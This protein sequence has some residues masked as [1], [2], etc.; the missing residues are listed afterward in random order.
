[1]K[2][3]KKRDNPP[4]QR[5]TVEMRAKP[6]G[7]VDRIMFQGQGAWGSQVQ[8]GSWKVGTPTQTSCLPLSPA[9]WDNNGDLTVAIPARCP[10][11]PSLYLERWG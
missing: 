1:M 8:P 11:L 10:F 5:V 9:C 7:L 3:F 4:P 2:T 6:H